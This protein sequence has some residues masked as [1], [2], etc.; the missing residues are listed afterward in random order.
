MMSTEKDLI[1]MSE[2]NLSM[3]IMCTECGA[4]HQLEELEGGTNCP[5]CKADLSK[6]LF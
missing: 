6:E 4:M 2:T 1:T 5:D 3:Q